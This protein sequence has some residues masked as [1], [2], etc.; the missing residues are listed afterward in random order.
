MKKP[1]MVLGALLFSLFAFTGSARADG[2]TCGGV[3]NL[4][5]PGNEVCQ[6]E[7]STDQ[8]GICE[9]PNGGGPGCEVAPG[10]GPA[11]AATF[12]LVGAALLLGRRRR[13]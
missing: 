8:T 9:T 12:G 10:G 13:R 6:H 5:C 4:Q 7:G 1:V 2:E 3:A 11:A